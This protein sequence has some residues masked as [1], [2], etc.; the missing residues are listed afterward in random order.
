MTS[1]Q[2]TWFIA[3]RTLV[4]GSLFT[5]FWLGAQFFVRRLDG[6]LALPDWTP[7]LGLVLAVA[8]GLVGLSCVVLFTVRGRGTPAPFDPPR[9]FIAI[10]PYRYCRNPMVVGF[11]VL[12]AGMAL[13]ER[14][15]GALAVAALVFLVGYVMV[16][17]WEER[18][19]RAKFGQ[20]YIDYCRRVPRWIPRL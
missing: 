19:L 15:P 13:L 2:P 10:G 1:P 14:S 17:G 16:V 8:G 7:A 20:P 9:L 5:A 12:L 18:H 4:F 3:L 11:C 6:G